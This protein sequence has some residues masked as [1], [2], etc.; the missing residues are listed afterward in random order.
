MLLQGKLSY[1]SDNEVPLVA[2]SSLRPARCLMQML[3]EYPGD[4]TQTMWYNGDKHYA[5][6]HVLNIGEYFLFSVGTGL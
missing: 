6:S 1:L 5:S 4:K 3:K 2:E